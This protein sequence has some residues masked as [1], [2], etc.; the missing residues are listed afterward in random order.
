MS[1]KVREADW[2][3]KGATIWATSGLDGGAAFMLEATGS[4][5]L[6]AGLGITI[7]A[8]NSSNNIQT[9]NLPPGSLPEDGFCLRVDINSP[10]MRTN[11]PPIAPTDRQGASM[12]TSYQPYIPLTPATTGGQGGQRAPPARA[13]HA[14]RVGATPRARIRQFEQQRNAERESHLRNGPLH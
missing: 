13:P 9:L 8:T 1:V 7:T 11:F 2:R 3:N 4:P 14:W 10:P 12:T 6:H 5:I